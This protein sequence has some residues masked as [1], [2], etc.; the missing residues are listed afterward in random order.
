MVNASGETTGSIVLVP[1]MGTG[2][3]EGM[4]AIGIEQPPEVGDPAISSM[5]RASWNKAVTPAFTS[6]FSRAQS[7]R[8]RRCAEVT[9]TGVIPRR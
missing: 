7:D 2:T 6:W 4:A 1:G 5:A 9:R 3:R 8:L